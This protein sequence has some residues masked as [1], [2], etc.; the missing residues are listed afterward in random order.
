MAIE[1]NYHKLKSILGLSLSLAK[2]QFKLKNEGS[3]LGVFWYLL[4]P[5]AL[6]LIILVIQ[7][8]FA[9]E[10]ISYYPLYLL[11]GLIM[12]NFFSK[13][14]NRASR[15]IA[16]N[17]GFIKSIKISYESLVVS[18][19]LEASFS[20][21]FEIILFVIFMLIFK[22]PLAGLIFYPLIFGFVFIF[23]LG[24]SFILT[25]LGTYINDL[26]NVWRVINRLLFF[27]T[28]LFYIT[29]KNS[30]IYKLNLF[31]PIFYYISIARDIII[32]NSISGLWIIL[33]AITFSFIFLIL[34]IIIFEKYKYKFAELV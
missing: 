4:E 33:G 7:G 6:F 21:F 5:L 26:D 29:V 23:V 11:L 34:G 10:G 13:T 9:V 14:T 27:A 3:Y 16:D 32:Y 19:V 12:F 17:S 31:N 8:V 24:L 20:H 25:T 1:E 28:P 22:A 18:E 30:F 15:I 2:A